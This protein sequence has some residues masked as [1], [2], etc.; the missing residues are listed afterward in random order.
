MR[1]YPDIPGIA[2]W[3]SALQG[4]AAAQAQLRTLLP[5]VQF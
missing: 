3:I 5:D 1:R 2:C 4:D